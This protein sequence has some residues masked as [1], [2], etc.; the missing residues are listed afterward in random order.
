MLEIELN[1]L[2]VTPEELSSLLEYLN[3]KEFLCK[4]YIGGNK[5]YLG[6]EYGYLLGGVST[7]VNIRPVDEAL[8]LYLKTFG[9]QDTMS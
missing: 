5:G 2:L 6:G 9:K 1:G 8:Y 3:G 7:R 4:K